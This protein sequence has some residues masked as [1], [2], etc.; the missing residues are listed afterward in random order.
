MNVFSFRFFFLSVSVC[1]AKLK[2]YD[3]NFKQTTQ[4]AVNGNNNAYHVSNQVA[5]TTND[6]SKNNNSS[7]A[8]NSNDISAPAPPTNHSQVKNDLMNNYWNNAI[9]S[10]EFSY[11]SSLQQPKHNNNN[12]RSPVELAYA[13][14]PILCDNQNQKP[15]SDMSR[16]MFVRSDSILTDDDYVPFDAPAQSKY[17]PISRMSAKTSPYSTGRCPSPVPS[18]Y[19]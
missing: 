6:Q 19:F 10:N 8:I 3:N 5:P 15:N 13:T 4:Q 16:D 12:S 17:G 11:Q 9:G 2:Q 18:Y 7:N 1:T 14:P